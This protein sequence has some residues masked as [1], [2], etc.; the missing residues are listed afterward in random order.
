MIA[1]TNGHDKNSEARLT[2]ASEFMADMKQFAD[3]KLY[4]AVTA[5]AYFENGQIVHAKVSP[6]RSLRMR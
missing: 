2:V 5:T 4:G 1:P 3:L 6:E